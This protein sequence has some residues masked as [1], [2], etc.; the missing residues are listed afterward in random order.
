MLCQARRGLSHSPKLCRGTRAAGWA[1]P[2]AE[3]R[4]LPPRARRRALRLPRGKRRQR[5][6]RG[7]ERDREGS[8][9][10]AG[11]SFRRCGQGC[12]APPTSTGRAIVQSPGTRA[13]LA[14]LASHNHCSSRR[15]RSQEARG[16]LPS[17]RLKHIQLTVTGENSIWRYFSLASNRGKNQ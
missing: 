6:G 17:C 5:S 16:W 10:W 13:P 11:R 7:S 15:R 1:T 12:P 8:S 4:A 14:T 2:I 9:R 3:S